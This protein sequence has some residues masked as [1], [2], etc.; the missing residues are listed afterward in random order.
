LDKC[1]ETLVPAQRIYALR[2]ENDTAAAQWVAV[3]DLEPLTVTQQTPALIRLAVLQLG[4][5]RA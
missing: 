1:G 2:A 4:L 3:V 5:V